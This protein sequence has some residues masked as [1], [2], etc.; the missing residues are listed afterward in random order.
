MNVHRGFFIISLVISIC[1]LPFYAFSDMNEEDIEKL[2][3]IPC[4]TGYENMMS[5]SIMH[6]IP[7]T[8]AV[9]RGLLGSVYVSKDGNFP[10]LSVICGMD[11]V[12]YIVG[13][14]DSQGTITLDR[15]V[16]APHQLFDSFF[17][18]HSME[19]WTENGPVKGVL[20]IPSLHIFPREER[21]NF[22]DYFTLDTMRLDVGAS[23]RE[24]VL[25][26]GIRNCAPV[27]PTKKIG[28]LQDRKM[29]G[30]FLGQK[31]CTALLLKIAEKVLSEENLGEVTIGWL[32]QTKMVSRGSN[33]RAC[34]GGVRAEKS[35]D[36]FENI[37]IGVFQTD[38]LKNGDIHIG[39]GPVLINKG[40]Q[41]SKLKRLI[42]ESAES[43]DIKIQT[44]GEYESLLL[45][46]F[47]GGEKDSAGLFIPAKFAFSPSEVIDFNDVKAL[48]KLVTSILSER[49]KR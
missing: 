11:E 4:P 45:N 29:V 8:G 35:L 23:S 28:H 38:G 16:P 20:A 32:A 42:L 48:E 39:E 40:R 41:D 25:R 12:G 49:R 5:E 47:S 34:V 27:T 1:C 33:P 13:G 30:Y 10:H 37:I 43:Q 36:S 7:D 19:V 26:K 6:Q 24:Q 2:Y 18:G 21:E 15:V 31:A 46:A 22:A 17:P 3:F 14:I 44:A 9:T